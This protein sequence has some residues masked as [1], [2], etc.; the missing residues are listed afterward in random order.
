MTGN[1]RCK[2][3]CH[4]MVSIDGKIDGEYMNSPNSEY[5]GNYYDEVFFKL[6]DSMAGGRNTACM[7]HANA[8]VD[9]SKFKN[10]TVSLEDNI[11]LSPNNNYYFCFDRLGKCNWDT[12]VFNYGGKEMPIVEVLTN[13]VRSE[14]LAY[15]KH[16]NIGYII[17]NKDSYLKDSLVKMK[18]LYGVDTLVLTGGAKINGAFA[19]EDLIDEISLT[20]AP[21]IEGNHDLKGISES[22]SFIDNSFA[23]YKALPLEDGGVHLLFKKVSK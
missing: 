20:V 16:M 3:I 2:V 19:N 1:K 21:Y 13:E 4:M 11:V 8:K 18:K 5:T 22:S 10:E 6:G 17:L 14:Y 9:Y 15:L 23:F 12:N 7:Y